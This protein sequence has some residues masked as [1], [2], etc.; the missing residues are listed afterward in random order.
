MRNQLKQ[1]SWLSEAGLAEALVS[2]FY[3]KNRC[4]YVVHWDPSDRY[5]EGYKDV[6]EPDSVRVIET[7]E[8]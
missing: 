6:Y 1:L 4:P 8:V 3:D 5:P 2:S 7:E